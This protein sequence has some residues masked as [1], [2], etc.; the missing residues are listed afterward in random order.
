MSLLKTLIPPKPI[1]LYGCVICPWAARTWI[2]L[3]QAN[4]EFEYIEIDLK[5]KPE[6]FLKEVNPGGKVPT[7]KYGDDIIIE[8]AI[9]TEFVADLFPEAKLILDDPFLRAQGRLMADRFMEYVV[10]VYR[11]LYFS[12]NFDAVGNVF[13][14]IDKFLPYLKDAK[15]F[16]GGSD[17]MTLAEIM[18]APFLS[19]LYMI[20]E[21][22]FVSGKILETLTS[23]PKYEYFNTWAQNILAT[24]GLKGTFDKTPNLNWVKERLASLGKL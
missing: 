18:I 20:L 16:F 5:N 24:P 1:K 12:G 13:G 6:W 9:T 2:V 14:A 21:S 8:S 3:T 4:V 23:D 19:R 10:P 15:P 22:E 7:L 17:H 11:E